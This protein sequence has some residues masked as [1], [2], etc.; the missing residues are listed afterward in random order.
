MIVIYSPASRA[1]IRHTQVTHDAQE[2]NFLPEGIPYNAV[3]F[4]PTE[5]KAALPIE[6]TPAIY[7]NDEPIRSY[8]FGIFFTEQE[9][10]GAV[11]EL[12]ADWFN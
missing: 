7:Y 2:A 12:T 5:D 1:E 8:D 11:A 6:V 9:K 10:A 4:H 3:I